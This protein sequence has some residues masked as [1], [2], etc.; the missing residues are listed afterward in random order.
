MKRAIFL[1]RDGV[2]VTDKGYIHKVEDM[3]IINGVPEAIMQLNLAGF[4]IVIV[5]PGSMLKV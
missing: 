5:V 1:D 3:D 2:I 4:V